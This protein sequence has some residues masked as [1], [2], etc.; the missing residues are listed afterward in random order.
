MIVTAEPYFAVTQPSDVVVMENF[1]R[2]DTTG[3]IEEIDA[4]YELLQR[5]QLRVECEARLYSLPVDMELSKVG[6]G[7]SV[8][9]NA[10][11]SSIF[12]CH[13]V[14]LRQLK[15]VGE[16][17]PLTRTRIQA[18]QGTVPLKYARNTLPARPGIL[19]RPA[20]GV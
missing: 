9:G 6:Y 17:G 10:P 7:R 15:W 19:Y 3:T 13:V 11:V 18:A 20:L 1:V 2:K 14:N 8:S 16:T 5:G 12:A 4:K